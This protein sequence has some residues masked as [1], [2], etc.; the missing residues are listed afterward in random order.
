MIIDQQF[1]GASILRAD[2]G[3]DV[4]AR[5]VLVG[6][7]ARGYVIDKTAEKYWRQLTLITQYAKTV[8]SHPALAACYNMAQDQLQT[9][10]HVEYPALI[11]MI[12]VECGDDP[13]TL[14]LNTRNPGMDYF[15][16]HRGSYL[17]Y[18]VKNVDVLTAC[19]ERLSDKSGSPNNNLSPLALEIGLAMKQSLNGKVVNIPA[20]CSL[21]QKSGNVY[22]GCR[23]IKCAFPGSFNHTGCTNCQGGNRHD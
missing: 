10:D 16:A 23:L 5:A 21:A 8:E 4:V 9:V 18:F 11:D 1:M 3:G 13:E 19:C 6:L 7:V 17:S 2:N 14:N 12:L 15:T 22:R 20:L